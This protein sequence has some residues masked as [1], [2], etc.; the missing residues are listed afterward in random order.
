MLC[1]DQVRILYDRGQATARI[2]VRSKE[3]LEQPLDM[4]HCHLRAMSPIHIKCMS[5][6]MSWYNLEC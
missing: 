1:A 4:T 5:V 6:Q 2:V 3:D